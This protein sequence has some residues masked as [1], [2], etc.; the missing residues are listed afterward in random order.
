MAAARRPAT[1]G[2]R[3]AVTIEDV[4]KAAGVSRQTVSNVL[5][6]PARV[7]ADTL[8][9]V[10]AAIEELG[11][12]PD[13]SARSLRTGERRTLAYLAPVDS[14]G[15]P[16]PL[17]GGFL[18]A[19]VDAAGDEGYRILLFRPPPGTVDP[20]PSMDEVIAARQ[21][22][23]FLLSDV[24]RSDH[25]VDHLV[26]AGVPFA[27]FGRTAPGLPQHW[28]DLDNTRA[29]AAV[30]GHLAALGHRRVG[31]LG[32][33]SELP[34]MADRRE[35][36]SVGLRDHGL[37]GTSALEPLDPTDPA[38]TVDAVRALLRSSQ[39]PT[40][41]AAASDMLAVTAYEAI[42]AE[43]LTVGQDVAVVGFHDIPLCR[44]LSP[45]LSSVRLPLRAIAS[46]LVAR[47]LSQIRGERAP[48]EGLLL[49]GELVVRTS[50][51]RGAGG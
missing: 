42:R 41:I 39:R 50:S 1:R 24:L 19:L 17:M 28:V 47:L 4:A 32:A 43:G 20:R 51:A 7:R 23:G 44:I 30:A 37:E 38:D 49:P 29:M 3:D 46:G 16:N 26:R 13:Q 33:S 22:D 15:D 18:E 9:R 40:A 14:P 31:Y 11:Y 45:A 25:R 27:V 34:W 21:A 2:G 8:A 36:F 48:D 12:R 5:N 6:A 35:G 10:Q